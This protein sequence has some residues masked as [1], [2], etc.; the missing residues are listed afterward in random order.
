MLNGRDLHIDVEVHLAEIVQDGGVSKEI[1]VVRDVVCTVCN[2][3]RERGGSESMACYS[4]KGLGVKQDALFNRETRCNTCKGHGKLVRNECTAC[5]GQGLTPKQ[6][7]VSVAIE[8]FAGDGHLVELDLQ[9]HRTLFGERG[10]K[11]GTLKATVRI[12]EEPER[13]QIG[14]DV[15]T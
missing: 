1:L 2:G 14:N 5:Q 13:Q 9:G 3:S 8:R 7:H 15:H 4:C 6:E 11:N 10:G 12:V